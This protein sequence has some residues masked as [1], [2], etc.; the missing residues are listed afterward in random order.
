MTR[1]LSRWASRP[2]K[3]LLSHSD[4]E[5]WR[6]GTFFRLHEYLGAHP[7]DEGCR[8]AVWAPRADRVTVAGDFNDWEPGRSP[9]EKE[10][11]TG[12]WRGEVAE[13]GPGDRYKFAVYGAGDEEPAYKADPMAFRTESPPG[14]ASVV[15]ADREYGWGDGGW[16]E[17]RRR[18]QSADRP[19]AIYELHLGSWVREGEKAG[20]GETAE[21]LAAYARKMNFTHIELMPLAEYPYGASW[22]Y[23]VTGFF[24]PTSRYGTPEGLKRLV[25][26]CHRHDIGVFMDWVPGHFPKDEHGLY[27]FDGHPLYEHPDPRRSD[28]P[29]WGTAN[30]NL[31]RGEVRS[32]LLSSACYWCREFHLDGLRV[33]AVSSMIYLDYSRGEGEWLPNVYGGKEHLGAIAFLQELNTGLHREFPGLITAAEESTA[34]PGVTEEQDEGG[35]GFDYKWNLGWMNDTLHYFSL[36]PEARSAASH[37]ITFPGTYAF[38]E[39]YILPFSHDEVVHLK[40]SLWEKMPGDTEWKCRNLRLLYLYWTGFPG[41]KLLFMGGEWGQKGE[42]SEDEALEWHLLEEEP[43][44]RVKNYFARLLDFY[45]EEPALYGEEAQWENF[46]WVDLSRSGEGLL[47]FER[48]APGSGRRLLFLFNFGAGEKEIETEFPAGTEGGEYGAR[49]SGVRARP[50]RGGELLFSSLPDSAG[51]RPSGGVILLEAC[52]GVVLEAKEV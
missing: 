31:E 37:S 2:L 22:G 29:D 16:M 11:E 14:T 40:G 38:D 5:S 25:D 18:R 10:P 26:I 34:W 21:R 23:Q 43:H 50:V 7:L 39:R 24:A 52:S 51:H 3:T 44:K 4:L 17:S 49:E 9:L 42:W 33:D 48:R 30:M 35:L 46:R 45:R 20:Y 12:I 47:H 8:F 36:E 19:M 28:H 15:A 1:S 41:K 27:R 6:K 32:F 13:A